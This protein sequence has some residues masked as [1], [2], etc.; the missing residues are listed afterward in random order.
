MKISKS[1]AFFGGFNP[2]HSTF[3]LF[4]T[5]V[6]NPPLFFSFNSPPTTALVGSPFGAISPAH[7]SGLVDDASFS[8]PPSLP[9]D[10]TPLMAAVEANSPEVVE[11]LLTVC[12][13]PVNVVD[14]DGRTAAHFLGKKA[15]HLFS[16][17]IRFSE[18]EG[19]G[20]TKEDQ[21]NVVAIITSLARNG[22]D[23]NALDAKGLTPL[24]NL[25]ILSKTLSSN[26]KQRC[27]FISEPVLRC[28][29]EVGADPCSTLGTVDN[30]ANTS[31][32]PSPSILSIA[33]SLILNFLP[34]PKIFRGKI[35]EQRIESAICTLLEYVD[36]S[37]TENLTAV[38]VSTERFFWH[39]LFLPRN[40]ALLE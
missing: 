10:R 18:D 15:L 21:T 16:P 11:A 31:G 36:P 25:A 6:E 2:A 26:A 19:F 28:L 7:E 13:A 5:P 32:T 22:A 39:A 8:A 17:S 20:S 9:S 40:K 34:S 4:G 12:R 23:M 33:M 24:A 38:A 1:M 14:K 27:C 37:L 29:L 35:S 30:N 3:N